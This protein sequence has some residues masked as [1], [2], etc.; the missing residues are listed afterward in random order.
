MAVLFAVVDVVT[1]HFAL[2]AQFGVESQI[3][4][5]QRHQRLQVVGLQL[6]AVVRVILHGEAAAD[7]VVLNLPDFA[8]VLLFLE[9]RRETKSAIREG[10]E[11]AEAEVRTEQSVP[12][13]CSRE[14]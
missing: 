8:G 2:D 11:R 12:C 7:A 6:L 13:W 9:G 3:G 4:E 5:V 14:G 10:T 1:E